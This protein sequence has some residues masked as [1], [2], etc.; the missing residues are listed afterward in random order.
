MGDL[1]VNRITLNAI[2]EKQFMKVRTAINWLKIVRT[3]INWLKIVRTAINWLKIE[4]N[5]GLL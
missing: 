4:F 1:G 3:A 2:S 5:G